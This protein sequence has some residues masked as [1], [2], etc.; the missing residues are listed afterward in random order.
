M[1]HPAQ[2]RKIIFFI[3]G[4]S[5]WS[6]IVCSAFSIA[7]DVDGT[8][9]TKLSMMVGVTS[10][11]H[12]A[13]IMT[14]TDLFASFQTQ[15]VKCIPFAGWWPFMASSI[16]TRAEEISQRL[17]E[18]SDFNDIIGLTEVNFALN[19]RESVTIVLWINSYFETLQVFTAS[20]QAIF[21]KRKST[22]VLGCRHHIYI[23]KETHVRP[24]LQAAGYNVIFGNPAESRFTFNINSGLLFATK[25]RVIA[26]SFTQFSHSNSFD[27]FSDKGILIVRLE[28]DDIGEVV[29]GLT[30][31]QS[32]FDQASRETRSF[33]LQAILK[34]IHR[35]ILVNNVK[36]STVSR[37]SH[38]GL[39][40]KKTRRQL[41]VD[42]G[43]VL[44][45]R[46]QHWCCFDPQ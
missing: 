28:V 41:H 10:L 45:G 7:L 26:H 9:P 32:G 16:D 19:W 33:Q 17:I 15:N 21:K 23:A 27:Q 34:A 13:L 25:S 39:A 43:C 6:S 3:A 46:S 14:S 37:I 20:S 18:D 4:V 35:F 31:L 12:T 24:D 30:H 8:V 5:V 11:N 36:E 22:S 40:H 1:I 29:V 42:I 2:A 44:N 38:E